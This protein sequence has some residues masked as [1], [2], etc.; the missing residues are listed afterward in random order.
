LAEVR[1]PQE[2]EVDQKDAMPQAVVDLHSAIGNVESAI[3]QVEQARP[4]LRLSSLIGLESRSPWVSL[5]NLDHK[6][7]SH[8][9]WCHMR[10]TEKL[11][12]PSLLDLLLMLNDD[13]TKLLWP[14]VLRLARPTLSLSP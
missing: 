12:F 5:C 10:D 2:K 11:V 14:P 1:G 4:V 7:V 8:E 3:D 6:Y 13:Q 9:L